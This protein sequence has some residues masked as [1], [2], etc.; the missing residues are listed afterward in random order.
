MSAKPQP[1]RI[2]QPQMTLEEF[3]NT[4]EMLKNNLPSVLKDGGVSAMV[5]VDAAIKGLKKV[6]QA[7]I[8]QK[9]KTLGADVPEGV[10][11]GIRQVRR[12]ET[13]I[14]NELRWRS[15]KDG[16]KVLHIKQDTLSR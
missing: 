2:P 14:Y 5:E 4:L 16:Q 3:K 10:T 11:V 6:V 12:G 9:A 15:P 8:T 13:A 7:E 1:K